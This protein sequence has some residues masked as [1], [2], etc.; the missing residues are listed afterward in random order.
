MIV[1]G[2]E[3]QTAGTGEPVVCLHGIGG[4]ATSFDP[5]LSGLDGYQVIAWNM[6]GYGQSKPLAEP[7]NFE[8]LSMALSEFLNALGFSRVHLVGQSIGGMLALE[9]ACRRSDQVGSL[10]LIGTTPRF[11]GKDDSFKSEFLKARLSPLDAGKTMAEIAAIS[12]PKLVGPDVG[13][14]VVKSVQEPLSRV[15]EKTWRDILN[16]LV[17]FDRNED[18][19]A[20]AHA[21][22]VVAGSHDANA[23]SKTMAKMAARLPKSQFHEIQGAGHMINQE[24]S[25]EFNKIA[26]AF[27]GENML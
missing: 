19:P 23:P 20:I 8:N 3:Y 16:C 15:P 21:A 17:T 5:Q 22:C 9:H 26:T 27:F 18:L 25:L 14:D 4:D 11:G 24:L 12:A 13:V 7:S 1:N 2:I 6:P 10:T